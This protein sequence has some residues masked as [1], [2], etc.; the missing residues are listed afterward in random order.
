M[1]FQVPY[2]SSPTTPDKSRSLFSDISATPADAPPSTTKS[3]T[4]R[5]P[6]PSTIF[7]S[8]QMSPRSQVD[9]QSLFTKSGG[10]D[11]NDSIF[12]SSVGS[13]HQPAPRAK[14][15]GLGKSFAAS[16]SL[17][18]MTK[19][20][21]FGES[22]GF[23]MSNGF[24]SQMDAETDGNDEQ[25]PAE[26]ED[27]MDIGD[28][29]H[30]LSFLD[31]QFGNPTQAQSA[32]RGQRKSI[33]SNP[34][35]A[36][37]PKL[38]EKWAQQSPLRKGKLS[39]KKDSAMPSIV[40]NFAS[41]AGRAV[42]NEPSDV[43]I[44][45]EDEMC[46]MYDEARQSEFTNRDSQ[47]IL[48]EVC[49]RLT[50]SWKPSMEGG[51]VP[52]AP[53][54][55]TDIGP[56][57]HAS[58]VAK[59]S[60]L[61]SLLLQLHH[62]PLSTAKQGNLNNNL[63]FAAPRSLVI[64]GSKPDTPTP[65]PKV[66]LDWLEAY[67]SSQP[68]E[69]RALKEVEPNPT[70]SSNFWEI[71]NAAVLR[72]RFSEAADVLRSADFNY[73]RSAL[74]DGLPESGYR[75]AQLQNIQRC[76]NKALQ[77]LESSPSI[78][79]D[80]WDVKGAEWALYRKRVTAAVTD[81]EEFA[82]GGEQQPVEPPVTDNRFQAINFGLKPSPA[83]ADFSFTKSARMAE[84]RVPWTIYQSL[85]CLY[86]I[87]LGD[88]NAILNLAQDWIEATVA[89]TV[90]W[91]GED[92]EEAANGDALRSGMFRSQAVRGANE[93]PVNAYLKRLDLAFRSA[94]NEEMADSSF[95]V[96]PLSSLEV[97][98]ASV[99]E[100]NV[101]G[102]L[103]LIQT[104][105]LCIASAVAEVA[106][107]GRWL[108]TER[109]AKPLPGLSEND[110]MVLS[111]GQ[112]GNEPNKRVRKDDLLSSYALGLFKRR[113]IEHTSG[114]REGWELAL[115]VVSRLD[116][117]EKLQKSVSEI[118]D[119]LP[120]DNVEQLD[121]V[122]LLC[123]EL[124]LDKEGR[125][126]SERFGDQT[127]ERSDEYGLALVCYAR[128]HSRRKVKSV[129]DL[130][131]SYS[132][133]QSR[134]YPAS[135]DLD[136]QLEALIRDPKTCLSAIAGSDEDAASILQYYFSGYATLR[137]FYEIRDEAIG[138]KEGQRPRFKPLARRR[139]AAQALVAVISSAADSIYGG[140]Y[141]PGRDSAVQVDGLLTLLGEALPFID[142]NTP[143]LSMS[144]QFT[145]LS[146]I[147]D[148][149]TVT[150]RVYAQCEECFRSTLIEYH[151]S[152]RAS[153]GGRSAAESYVLPPSPRA[154]LKKSVS[155]LTAS[156]TFSFI[157]SDMIESA[158]NRTMSG[159]GSVT[160]SGVLVPRPGDGAQGSHERGWDWRAALPEDIK[161]E[162]V[163]KMLRLGLARG[164][165]F[166]AL[167]SI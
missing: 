26:E 93:D 9:S 51:R 22:T 27:E 21:A 119:K 132:L 112:N 94:I 102:V 99:F 31:S 134:A 158:R 2:G 38:D 50:D 86:R 162:E 41:R 80:D 79:Y 106:S 92:D 7:G 13:F 103:E 20:T 118:L 121:K 88:A 6:P 122:V 69:V 62:P 110:L 128:A 39:P 113:T 53:G 111:Y 60:F 55:G 43:I 147:E 72:G 42:V 144:Q 107:L 125:R 64:A 166:G 127:V 91:D 74:E 133:V 68:D 10:V 160:G 89:L 76:V 47:I 65:I 114:V 142:Q 117:A 100:G 140:L 59:A 15:A 164:L 104:W 90:W 25:I 131:I 52:K 138:L 155:S 45:T 63:G 46:R 108:D 1:S 17:F 12:N 23:G 141:D 129:V 85:R 58:G 95:R 66:L 73:A 18:S 28:P 40:R 35:N 3:F 19:N 44:S 139:A 152:E 153:S 30:R 148:L 77:L 157:G 75:G 32:S 115:E 130:L 14:N 165:S 163:L 87:I 154:L 83:K 105:S 34:G 56:G 4:P 71:V 150:P 161:G 33:Y 167:G 143:V 61:G 135:A 126:V 84:S 24:T 67:H 151:S 37:R 97:G 82:E 16:Q 78:Q 57:D 116:D 145:I 54:A 49:S 81:L 124:G 159:S 8:S 70:A 101:D 11:F 146:A 48:S 98:L 136:E 109:G 137:R 36:K 123:S 5:G 96:N 29:E 120:L 149:E 156:S